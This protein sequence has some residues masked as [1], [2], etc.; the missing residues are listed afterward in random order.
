ML[1]NTAFLILIISGNIDLFTNGKDVF[2]VRVLAN[3]GVLSGTQGDFSQAWYHAVRRI[4]ESMIVHR[5]T[6]SSNLS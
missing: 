6:S 2:Y 3:I 1:V 4:Y 5:V